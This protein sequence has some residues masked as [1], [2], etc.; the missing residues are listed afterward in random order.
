MDVSII[1]M[2][3]LLSEV[4][5]KFLVFEIGT[6]LVECEVCVLSSLVWHNNIQDEGCLLTPVIHGA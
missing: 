2:L 4:M 1:Q 3:L 5:N 6:N